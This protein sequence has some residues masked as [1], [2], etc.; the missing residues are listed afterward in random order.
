MAREFLRRLGHVILAIL[1]SID[2]LLLV[3]VTAPLYLLGITNEQPSPDETLSSRVAR[4][5]IMGHRWAY[6]A[7]IAIN[8][9]FFWQVDETGRRAH[10]RLSME[11]GRIIRAA[12]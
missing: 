6:W 4:Y 12:K 10:C 5:S 2:Q 9:L 8:L 11:A 1:I 7:E 3:L